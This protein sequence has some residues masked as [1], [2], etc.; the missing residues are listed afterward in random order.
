MDD[1]KNFLSK[2]RKILTHIYCYSNIPDRSS[3]E[4]VLVVD[5]K[6]LSGLDGSEGC[7]TLDV[8]EPWVFK[9]VH[10]AVGSKRVLDLKQ[11]I[12]QIL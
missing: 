7:Y 1:I 12:K 5:S 6:L 4:L 3:V 11:N 8:A 10:L 9:V 2:I